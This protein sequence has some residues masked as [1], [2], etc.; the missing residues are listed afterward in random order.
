MPLPSRVEV[1]SIQL[2]LILDPDDRSIIH[3]ARG[4]GDVLLTR[5]MSTGELR[6]DP[7]G[8]ALEA[9]C[10]FPERYKG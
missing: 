4:Q 5:M 2:Y 3:H 10:L 8:I 1:S 9:E 7:P 6:F